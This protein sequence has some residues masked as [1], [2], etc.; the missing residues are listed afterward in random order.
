MTARAGTSHTSKR[1]TTIPRVRQILAIL[2]RE[3]KS[4]KCALVHSS[5]LELIVATILSAQCTDARVNQVTPALFA[6]YRSAAD[7]AEA[8][9]GR[10][11][12]DIRSTGFFRNKARAL[13]NLG[14]ALV[15]DH[16]GQVPRTM[17]ELTALPGVGRK[18]ANLVLAEA[19]GVPGIVVDTHVR[20]IT[21]RLGL[22]RRSDPDHI[23][24]DL[25]Q[26]IPRVSWN[27]F[28]LRLIQH[29]RAV[30]KARNPRCEDCALLRVCPEGLS[31]V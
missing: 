26:V 13:R 22:T 20:R 28:S 11:E 3:Y 31:R 9:A 2:A 16:H 7:Y 14:A 23:E 15:R 17:E 29:G 27:R 19:F 6:K 30:C 21:Q 1:A 12:E 5:P 18:T 24:R 4:P 25:M 10:L 8:P